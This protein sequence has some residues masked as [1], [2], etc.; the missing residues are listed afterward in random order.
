M[1]DALGRS[2]AGPA[3]HIVQ[4][5]RGRLGRRQ[6]GRDVGDEVGAV[7]TGDRGPAFRPAQLVADRHA[8]GVK[9]VCVVGGNGGAQRQQ[10]V[11]VARVG[12]LPERVGRGALHEGVAVAQGGDQGGGVSG[13]ANVSEGMDIYQ[14]TEN[15]ISLSA[16]ISGTKY[17]KDK[18]LNYR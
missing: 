13:A 5:E 14:F 18:Q 3:A 11:Q 15:G 10:R 1:A 2:G 7:A 12:V 16:T 17:W 6:A 4:Q 8:N 9:Q